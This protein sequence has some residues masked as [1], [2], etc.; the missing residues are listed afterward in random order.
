MTKK[1]QKGYIQAHLLHALLNYI[2]HGHQCSRVDL[3]RCLAQLYRIKG[4][5]V[6][7]LYCDA[8][9]QRCAPLAVQAEG[10]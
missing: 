3:N 2:Y 6:Y 5:G 10:Y 7:E 4:F 8:S 1:I 9:S